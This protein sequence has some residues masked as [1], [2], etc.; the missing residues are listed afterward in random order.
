LQRAYQT[1]KVKSTESKIYKNN[2]GDGFTE[3]TDISLAGLCY[4][5]SSWG[6]YDNNGDLDILITRKK[7]MDPIQDSV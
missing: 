6:D 7:F 1:S 5:T 3:Q 4:G 2:Q